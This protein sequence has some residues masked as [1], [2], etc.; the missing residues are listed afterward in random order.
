MSLKDE[1]PWLDGVPPA[2]ACDK[3]W[4]MLIRQLHTRIVGID[5]DYR[6]VQVKEKY[7]GLRYYVVMSA[8]LDELLH[9][10]VSEAIS[11][12]EEESFHI[13]ELCG[14]PGELN[15]G[16]WYRTRCTLH[17]GMRWLGDDARM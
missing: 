10:R 17:R 2:V 7:G 1:L 11:E 13:C 6:V 4:D 14:Q 3:G 5:P 16:P 15:D 9:H 12:A 8:G